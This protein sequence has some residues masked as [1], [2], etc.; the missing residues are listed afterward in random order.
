M[1][2]DGTL[3]ASRGESFF[4]RMMPRDAPGADVVLAAIER[5]Q[6]AREGDACELPV[7]TLSK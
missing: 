2:V 3:V 4:A 5:H 7:S 6:A 1:I